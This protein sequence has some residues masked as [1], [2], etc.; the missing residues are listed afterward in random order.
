MAAPAAL[1][2]RPAVFASGRGRPT[3]NISFA[4]SLIHL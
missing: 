4:M 3:F 2:E 1:P